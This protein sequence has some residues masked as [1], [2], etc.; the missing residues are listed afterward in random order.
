MS[1]IFKSVSKYQRN[2]QEPK[3]TQKPKGTLRNL[4]NP[5]NPKELFI[6]LNI[7]LEGLKRLEGFVYIGIGIFRIW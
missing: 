1:I 6:A 4:K 3:E 7:R 2:P 5:R